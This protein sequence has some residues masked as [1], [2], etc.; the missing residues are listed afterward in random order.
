MS[1]Y[2]ATQAT[3]LSNETL[4]NRAPSIFAES[5][6]HDRSERYTQI[7][8]IQVVEALRSEGWMPVFANETKVRDIESRGFGK[9]MLRFR[10]SDDIGRTINLAD[11]FNEIVL[12]NSHDGTSS[13]QLNAGIFRLACAN[14]MVVSDSMLETQRIRHKGDIVNNVI[15]GV[16][17]IVDSLPEV[18]DKIDQYKSIMLNHQE[19]SILAK[20][21]IALKWEEDKAPVGESQILRV[22]RNEDNHGDL[23][24]TFNRIQEN[25]LKGGL[26]GYTIDDNGR[27]RR[28]TTREV[29]AVSE[30]VRL[31]KALWMLADEMA[32]IKA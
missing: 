29:K 14:G 24:T 22:R 10:H 28:T 19:Q 32:K 5:A 2:R 31:N 25:V 7:P 11:R 1:Y 3:V 6:K 13:Y 8:T 23:W 12:L 16:Y 18:N 27:H 17:S 4:F 15:E 26:R 21:A 9:H 30:N 20:T